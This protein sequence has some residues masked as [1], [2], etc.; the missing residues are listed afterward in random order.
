M[1][2]HRLGFGKCIQYLSGIVIEKR[3]KEQ[4]SK[5]ATILK[6]LREFM[7]ITKDNL[8]QDLHKY[9]I[10]YPNNFFP[11]QIIPKEAIPTNVMELRGINI[12]AI[13]GERFP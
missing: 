11:F 5:K 12:A 9:K 10:V 1:P 2:T 3:I 8:G 13:I 4:P 6:I 7:G